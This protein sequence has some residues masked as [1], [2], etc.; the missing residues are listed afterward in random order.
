MGEDELRT[1]QERYE[2]PVCWAFFRQSIAEWT[3]EREADEE[4]RAVDVPDDYVRGERARLSRAVLLAM[5]PELALI[6][7]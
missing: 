5:E 6:P 2:L 1:F 3:K 4:G 7:D